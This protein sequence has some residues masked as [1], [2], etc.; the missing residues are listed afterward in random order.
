MFPDDPWFYW[1]LKTLAYAGF[2]ALGG[3][4]GYTMRAL[5]KGTPVKVSRAIVEGFAAGFTGVII[6]LACRAIGFTDEWTGAAVGVSGWLGANWS[7]RFAERLLERKV[8]LPVSSE[9]DH[10][11]DVAK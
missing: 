6:L 3:A 10:D 1:W 9:T 7:I 8:G 5:D 2:A 4:L 11:N